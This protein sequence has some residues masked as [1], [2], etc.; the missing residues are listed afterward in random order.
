MPHNL[1]T[2][3]IRSHRW[4]G[5][6]V[7]I[8]HQTVLPGRAWHQLVS[9]R[10]ML[11]AVVDQI[12]GLCEAR[13]TID[14]GV[15][16]AATNRQRRVGHV[17]LIPQGLPVWGYSEDIAEFDEVRLM[18][19]VDR[20]SEVMN[21][22]FP[23]ERLSEPQLMFFDESLQT[24]ARLIARSDA[25]MPGFELYGDSLVTAIIARLSDLNAARPRSDRRL[26]LTERQMVQVTEFL[27][28]NLTEPVR[29]AELATLAGL[30][31]SQ[32]GRAFKVSTGTTPRKWHLDARIDYAKT[33]LADRRNGLV[34][35]ALD[36]GFCEQSQ[37]SR[38]FKA[39]TG[40]SPGEWR[41]IKLN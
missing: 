7:H 29:L 26:G 13:P 28:A 41:R 32:F 2:A 20:V 17:S 31:A 35:V 12:G 4:V 38:T 22:E 5:V 30:S 34:G 21:G 11:S 27:R 1:G 39:A 3:Q 8:V 15:D 37:F 19:D 10:P 24:L 40:F 36:A 9:D 16:R 14:A 18:L 33:L 25:E 23:V 6:D